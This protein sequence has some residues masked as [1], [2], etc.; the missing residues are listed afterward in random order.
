MLDALRALANAALSLANYAVSL[1]WSLFEEGKRY[2]VAVAKSF[3][4][5]AKSLA[6]GLYNEAVGT[7]HKLFNAVLSQATDLFNRAVKVAFDLAQDVKHWVLTQI[8][9]IVEWVKLELAGL[10]KLLKQYVDGL[11][12]QVQKILKDIGQIFAWISSYASE[13][14]AKLSGLAQFLT[15]AM[16]GR[17]IHVLQDMYPFLLSF[18]LNPL[19]FIVAVI[20]DALLTLLEYALAYGI[21]CDS[22]PLPPWPAFSFSGFGGLTPSYAPDMSGF[23]ETGWPLDQVWV[24]GYTFGPGH[25]AVD[26]GCH[27][28]DPVYAI[29]DGIVQEAGWSNFGY[30]YTVVIKGGDWW[31]RY[32]HLETIGVQLYEMVRKGQQIATANST[33]NSTGPHLHL[34]IKYKGQYIDPLSIL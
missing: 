29:H 33:G 31:S 8:Q 19:G 2:A 26:L 34:E 12:A 6:Y 7:A 21:G 16:L 28:G 24:S 11:S 17:L 27:V 25:P 1:I 14:L 5:E 13:I 23:T 22:E 30:G 9:P 20:K 15:P 4:A 32:A 18:L 10:S 3:V